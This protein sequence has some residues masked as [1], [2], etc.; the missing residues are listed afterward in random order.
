MSSLVVDVIGSRHI[1][2][3]GDNAANLEETMKWQ[4][5]LMV[6][7]V[8]R[9][10]PTRAKVVLVENGEHFT[11]NQWLMMRKNDTTYFVGIYPGFVVV[12]D[13]HYVKDRIIGHLLHYQQVIDLN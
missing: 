10:P 3:Y 5:Y 12:M 7:S 13:L 11:E 4:I 6:L 9:G 2:F 1:R 8:S